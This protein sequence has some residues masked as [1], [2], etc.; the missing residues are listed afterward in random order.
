[1]ASKPTLR[2]GNVSALQDADQKNTYHALHC[3]TSETNTDYWSVT[4]FQGAVS[5]GFMNR[6][7]SPFSPGAGTKL[8]A[9]VRITQTAEIPC[10]QEVGETAFG[11]GCCR[12][13]GTCFA[14][15]A[16]R[17]LYA[18]DGIKRFDKD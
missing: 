7:H 16:A 12:R 1:M 18:E 13:Q 14:C 4:S 6:D 3:P 8:L 10:Q 15:L 17:N 11:Y 5:T 2:T 9:H